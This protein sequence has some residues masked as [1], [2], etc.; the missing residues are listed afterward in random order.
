MNKF[1]LFLIPLFVAFC[2]FQTNMVRADSLNVVAVDVG[3]NY[4]FDD[5]YVIFYIEWVGL[6]WSEEEVRFDVEVTMLGKT[7]LC[8][9]D[10]SYF[11][12]YQQCVQVFWYSFNCNAY[13]ETT[14]PFEV[15]IYIWTPK[16]AGYER[17][18]H[19]TLTGEFTNHY[20]YIPEYTH[21]IYLILAVSAIVTVTLKRALNISSRYLTNKQQSK[22]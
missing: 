4:P 5:G 12:D 17:V 14:I 2:F 22:S 13:V 11:P 9:D 3:G 16:G 15:V 21:I 8:I 1:I 20:Y 10:K 19:A 7:R 18:Q 6:P